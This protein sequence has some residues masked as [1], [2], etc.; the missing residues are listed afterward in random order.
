MG[1]EEA[2]TTKPPSDIRGLLNLIL[3]TQES[4]LKKQIEMDA[5][6]H[7]LQITLISVIPEQNRLRAAQILQ[8]TFEEQKAI[9]LQALEKVLEQLALLRTTVSTKIQ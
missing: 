3:D 8:E 2:M 5:Q 9:R 7:A 6:I 4:Y 1:E